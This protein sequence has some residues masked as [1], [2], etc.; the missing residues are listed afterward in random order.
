MTFKF[1][2]RELAAAIG[3]VADGDVLV[4][5]LTGFTFDDIPI[6]GEDVVVILKK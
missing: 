6:T 4:L 2:N 5:T 1:G 3:E